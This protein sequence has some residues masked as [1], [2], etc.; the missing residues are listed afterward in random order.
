MACCEAQNTRYTEG[1]FLV[2]VFFV[3]RGTDWL[4]YAPKSIIRDGEGE[5]YP[6]RPDIV[7]HHVD[8]VRDVNDGRWIMKCY[9][10]RKE[11]P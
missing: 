6:R 5:T 3:S 1:E 2:R 8:C 9:Y 4:P 11:T 10:C 7:C